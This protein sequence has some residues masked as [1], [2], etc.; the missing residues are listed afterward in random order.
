MECVVKFALVLFILFVQAAPVVADET[1]DGQAGASGAM[2]RAKLQAI[3]RQYQEA[4]AGLND[5][6][7]RLAT[8]YE[9]QLTE[10][11][12][13]I[14]QQG[15]L[16]ARGEKLLAQQ[17]EVAAKTVE[18]QNRFEA[19]LATWAKQQSQ[20]QTYLDTLTARH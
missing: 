17:E 13:Q 11:R 7:K 6:E 1:S 14:D 2:D 18:N 19:I 5:Q 10:S 16:L 20:Y 3:Y 9:K 12:Q 8:E 4:L 15:A